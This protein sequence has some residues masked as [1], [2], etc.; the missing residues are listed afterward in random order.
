MRFR[1][2][3]CL[4]ILPDVRLFLAASTGA[5]SS[6]VEG[7]VAYVPGGPWGVAMIP[8]SP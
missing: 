8:L 4:P 2:R 6:V 3:P 1:F 5:G 7:Q